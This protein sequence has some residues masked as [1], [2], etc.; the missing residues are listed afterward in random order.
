MKEVIPPIIYNAN[1]EINWIE[2]I[3]HYT[4][5]ITKELDQIALN[6]L[7]Q[8][9]DLNT[10]TT[11]KNNNIHVDKI[12]LA[13]Q[14]VLNSIKFN[15]LFGVSQY[16][17]Q[18]Y[19]KT[20]KDAKL[21]GFNL[22]SSIWLGIKHDKIMFLT[23]TRKDKIREYFLEQLDLIKVFPTSIILGIKGDKVREYRFNT[24]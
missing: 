6:N 17:V 10:D 19:R 24:V 8:L 21:E 12:L 18:T 20:M 1:K 2:N 16:H 13:Q 14:V 3:I 15:T 9:Q 23:P 5:S 22:S 4:E 7:S 11:T